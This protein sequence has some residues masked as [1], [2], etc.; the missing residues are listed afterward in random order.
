MV[1]PGSGQ[2]I[3]PGALVPVEI[4]RALD[5]GTYHDPNVWMKHTV[6][7]KGDRSAS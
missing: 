3:V 6:A 4:D 7:S 1:F 5:I 2:Y